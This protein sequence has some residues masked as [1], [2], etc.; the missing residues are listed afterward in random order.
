MLQ[1]SSKFGISAL[2]RAKVDVPAESSDEDDEL[3]RFLNGTYDD[4]EEN[5]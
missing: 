4:E 2:D 1:V 5:D 3:D